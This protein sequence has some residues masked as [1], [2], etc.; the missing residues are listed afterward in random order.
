MLTYFDYFIPLL[1]AHLVCF[2]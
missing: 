2:P 1:I